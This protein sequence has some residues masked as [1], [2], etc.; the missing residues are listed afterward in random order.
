AAKN[1]VYAEVIGLGHAGGCTGED[2]AADTHMRALERALHDAET[3]ADQIDFIETLGS[4]IPDRD[5]SEVRALEAVFSGRSRPCTIGATLPGL[6]HAGAAAGLA[7]IVKT[8]LCLYREIIPPLPGFGEPAHV[9]LRRDVFQIPTAAQDW[10]SNHGGRRRACVGITTGD[11]DSYAV[12]LTETAPDLKS[13]SASVPRPSTPPAAAGPPPGETIEILVG[14]CVPV[15]RGPAG[16]NAHLTA[17]AAVGDTPAAAMLS[18]AP[19]ETARSAP[20]PYPDFR[21]PPPPEAAKPAPQPFDRVPVPPNLSFSPGQLIAAFNDSTAATAAAHRRFIDFSTEL[22]RAYAENAAGQVRLL[23]AL[24][25]GGQ[26]ADHSITVLPPAAF[27]TEGSDAVAFT[28]DQCLEFATGRA[29][30]VLGPDFAAVDTYATRVRLP[31]EPLM[32]VDR[33]LSITGRRRSLTAGHLVTEHDVRPGAWYLDGGRAPVCIAVEAGQADLFLCAYLGIDLAVKGRRV[34]RLLDA[35][36]IFQRDLP[37]PG[38]TIRYRIEIEKFIRQGETWLFFFG[39]E[40]TI[41]GQPLITM[42]GGCA[43]FFTPEEIENSGGIVCRPEDSAAQSGRRDKRLTEFVPQAVASFDEAA[44]D[45]LRAGDLAA[46]FGPAFDGII[47]PPALRLPGG[48]MKLIDR[49]ERLEPRGGRFGLGSIRAAA[50][51]HPDDWFLTCH[52][53]DDMT[54]PGT[55]MYECCAHALRVFLQRLGWVTDRP[56]VHYAPVAGI[57]SVLQC[58]GPVTPQT[59]RVIYE[60]DIKEIGCGPEP[61][62]LADAHMHAD[63]R[64]I[65]RFTDMTLRMAGLDPESIATFWRRRRHPAKT[66]QKN[67]PPRVLFTRRQLL[68]FATG[69]PSEA[70]GQPYAPFDRHRFL[71]RLPAPPYAFIDR[72]VAAEP[73]AW[74]LAPGGWVEAELDIDPAAWYF[75]ANRSD[76]LPYCVLLEIALQACGWLAAYLGSALHSRKDLHFRN[77]DGQAVQHLEVPAAPQTLRIRCRLTK[78]SRS[79]DII[80]EAFEFKVLSGNRLVYDGTTV[81]GFFTAEALAEQKGIP[82]EADQAHPSASDAQSEFTPETLDDQAP[83]T[84]ADPHFSPA[85]GLCLPAKALR[86][87]DRVEMHRPHGGRHNLGWLRASKHIDPAE[88]FFKAHFHQDPVCPGSLGIESLLQL[89]KYAALRRWPHLIDG[90]RFEQPLGVAHSW[91]YRGQIVPGNRLVEVDAEITRVTDGPIPE[92]HADGLLRVDG[93]TIYRMKNFGVKITPL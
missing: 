45:A 27:N 1:R 4:G 21:P 65:V 79:G 47:L 49:I 50:D 19:A 39:F 56:D 7:A 29:A 82:V 15:F 91:Q 67:D 9:D 28:R 46:A 41:D 30:D 57:K 88:W 51:I 32:L 22:G 62:A 81:F 6:G 14:G 78:V 12:V 2:A 25:G 63:G 85:T 92:L 84:P 17:A 31:D 70:F 60:V 93:L 72:I 10:P 61:Y 89:L 53:V 76:R 87:I 86:M 3:P 54:M 34:Y 42:T 18:L 48:R 75:R 5:R 64:C 83:L 80:I 37:R 74:Q 58:R 24:A 69:N 11:G 13:L 36:V 23:Q 52:F 35:G 77:L 8:A 68:A 55:L 66:V 40:G 43:G 20:A 33:I 90:H 44:L 26:D 16:I 59:R 71:A 38:D 73:Q